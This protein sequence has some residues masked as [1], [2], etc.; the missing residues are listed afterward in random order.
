MNDVTRAPAELALS[1]GTKLSRALAS[2]VL[3]ELGNQRRS[4]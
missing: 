3:E 1:R 4:D 2:E